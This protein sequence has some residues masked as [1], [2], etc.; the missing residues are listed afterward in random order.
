LR[1]F[2]RNSTVLLLIQS[3]CLNNLAYLQ[4]IFGCDIFTL[5]W[6]VSITNKSWTTDRGYFRPLICSLTYFSTLSDLQYGILACVACFTRTYKHRQ[7]QTF[8]AVNLTILF[9]YVTRRDF[10][11]FLT[12]FCSNLSALCHGVEDFLLHSLVYCD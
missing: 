10:D 2:P 12:N 6:I 9:L 11:Q 3:S 1:F 8:P 5:N 4:Q 7:K